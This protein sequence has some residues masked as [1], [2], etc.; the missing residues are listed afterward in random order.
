[1][2]SGVAHDFNNVLA[3]ILGNIQLLSYQLDHLSPEEIRE[4]LKAIERSSKDGAETVRRIQEFT[5]IRR[6][7]DFSPVSIN[8]L[9]REVIVMTEPRWKDQAQSRGIQI[10][11]STQF[12]IRSPSFSGIPPN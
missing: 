5:G 2:A 1:M 6:D 11:I 4:R 7:K 10:E 3:V 9:V 12:E 8:E